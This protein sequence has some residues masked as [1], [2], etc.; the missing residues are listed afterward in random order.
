MADR[1]AWSASEITSAAWNVN[2]GV[3][4]HGGVGKANINIASK[5]VNGIRFLLRIIA[6]D[7]ASA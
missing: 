7:G 5:N 2:S 1:S 6:G 4:G 3:G